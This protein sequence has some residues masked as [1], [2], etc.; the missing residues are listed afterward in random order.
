MPNWNELHNE[1]KGDIDTFRRKY[2]KQLYEQTGRN[3]IIYY[4]GWLQKPDSDHRTWAI[5]DEDKIGFMTAIHHLN[6][7]KGL[8]LILH[9]PGGD[10]AATE[11]IV[12]YLKTMFGTDI[13]AVVPQL[14]M[15]GGT[16]IARACKS[17]LMGKQ[18][19]LGPVDPQ[20]N[21][22]PAHGIIEE[23]KRAIEE[24]RADSSKIP[25]WQP[26]INK[27]SPALIGECEKSIKWSNELV[28]DWLSTNMFKGIENQKVDKIISELTDHA[29]T[30]SHARHLSA[31]KCADLGLN[32]EKLED[33]Q[34][35]QDTVLSVHHACML[36][37]SATAAIKIIENHNGIAFIRLLK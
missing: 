26:I 34:K 24:V 18:S 19:S 10:T 27:Y 32:I 14:A 6:R 4:S 16:M 28:R 20:H 30:L 15:S 36:T 23:F 12:D 11:S 2:L 3:V 25:I 17:I 1:V 35:L 21:G 37:F 31:E 9:T 22:I 13:R 7:G 5:N 33:N 8:D 29:L